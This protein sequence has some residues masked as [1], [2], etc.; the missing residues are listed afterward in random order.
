MDRSK[1]VRRGMGK[2]FRSGTLGIAAGVL[3]LGSGLSWAGPPNPT[4]SDVVGNTAGGTGALVNNTN[5]TD[6]TAFGHAALDVSTTGNGNTADG[7]GA[8][9]ANTTGS[10]N[11]ASGAFALNN[12]TTGDRNTASGTG[13]L[14]HN[15]TGVDN[16]GFGVAALYAAT[17]GNGNT[18]S[19]SGAL[20]NNTNGTDNTA[21]G[22]NAGLS[23]TTGS[24]NTLIGSD[25]DANAGVYT[26]GTALG[27]GAVLTASNSIVL[28]NRSISR[29][30]A[31]VAT[32]TGISDRRRKKDIK[33]LEA[34]LGLDFIEK[35]QPVS[36]R[37][38]NGDE[39]ERYGFIAQDLEQALP[40]S[41]H[42]TI[43]KSEPEH[44]L[45]LIERQ[46][47][48]D[49]TYRVSYGEL[50]APMV[51]AIQQQQQEIESVRQQNAELRQALVAVK[52]QVVAFKA[53]NDALRHSIEG[54]RQQVAAA[55]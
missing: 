21:V 9:N 4:P 54:L 1:R 49:R 12:N 24:R 38:N 50:T 30:F 36:Y 29:I 52:D 44:G 40:T 43:E 22:R 53:E 17:V 32:I 25:A 14:F 31:N 35:L 8:L 5:G 16:T 48:K 39:T 34:D 11:T 23:N 37:F 41:L 2:L 46:N 20:G 45:A 3:L 55:R 19:G 33:A 15:T 18:T 7:S 6:N 47:D 28:G 27:N 13:V 51:K 26:N 10:N 42:D